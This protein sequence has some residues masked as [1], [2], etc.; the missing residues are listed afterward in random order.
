MNQP[1]PS[2]KTTRRL[3]WARGTAPMP[4]WYGSQFTHRAVGQPDTEARSI[5][6]RATEMQV[7]AGHR[8][9][10]AR[11]GFPA[12][13][14][15]LAIHERLGPVIGEIPARRRDAGDGR[16]TAPEA[17]DPGST[18]RRQRATPTAP[19]CAA[20]RTLARLA[21]HSCAGAPDRPPIR[22]WQHPERTGAASRDGPAR[23]RPG[24]N[25][26]R[27]TAAWPPGPGQC[28]HRPV[29]ALPRPPR[30]AAAARG[31]PHGK[32][33]ERCKMFDTRS[34]RCD[35]RRVARAA[36]AAAASSDA[37]RSPG[38]ADAG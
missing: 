30:P 19:T 23:H 22:Q 11:H 9:L 8:Q 18:P 12:L 4:S 24:R 7:F 10:A 37:P 29:D 2:R 13:V 32:G 25:G 27:S 6:A 3:G 20:V 33:P 38:V 5:E 36:R 17:A 34:I 35:R 26:G 15:R 28:P 14:R 21:E 1:S 31:P 16:S